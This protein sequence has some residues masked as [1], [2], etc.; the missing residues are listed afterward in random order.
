[1]NTISKAIV[2]IANP[3]FEQQTAIFLINKICNLILSIVALKNKYNRIN[4]NK[5]L[6]NKRKQK[7]HRIDN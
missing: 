1:M 2:W 7:V 3:A 5:N 6:E 4:K